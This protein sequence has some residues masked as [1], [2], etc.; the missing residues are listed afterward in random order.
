MSRSGLAL[1]LLALLLKPQPS[2]FESSFALELQFPGCLQISAVLA[3][4][5]VFRKAAHAVWRFDH[6]FI[7]HW[8]FSVQT[9]SSSL[10]VALAIFQDATE[11]HRFCRML[12]ISALISPNGVF[13]NGCSSGNS[14]KLIITPFVYQSI[15]GASALTGSWSALP[16]SKSM[17]H[18]F[19]CTPEYH[20]NGC[21]AP[22]GERFIS[23]L[24]A[25]STPNS[26]ASSWIT[27]GRSTV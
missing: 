10:K 25:S 17:A 3:T 15:S 20:G 21:R 26:G 14:F 4:R 2:T 8:A 9:G 12:R 6:W 27:I 7:R 24:V 23:S 16:R 19:G 18:L 1:Q 22:P 11:R 13:R 5:P